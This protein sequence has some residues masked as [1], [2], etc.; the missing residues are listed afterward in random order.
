[1]HFLNQREENL[2][3]QLEHLIDEVYYLNELGADP[4]VHGNGFIQFDLTGG[5]RMHVWGDPR[6]PRQTV[7]SQIHDHTF[8]FTSQIMVGQIVHREIGLWANYEG[9]YDAYRPVTNEGED[10]RLV[11]FPMRYNATIRSEQLFK[12]GDTYT[13]EA[14]KFHETVAPWVC[15]TVIE[16]DKSKTREGVPPTVLVPHGL[17]PDNSFNR[18]QE[19]TNKLWKIVWEAL[20]EIVPAR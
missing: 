17:E 18:Y 19:D 10:T 8:S 9:A 11:K 4:R 16:K 1:M 7:P 13:F 20:H 6:I 12:E 2:H 14:Y 5:R 3:L 15:V